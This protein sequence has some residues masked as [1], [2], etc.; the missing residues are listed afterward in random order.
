M[1]E[2]AFTGLLI[3]CTATLGG[4]ALYAAARLFKGS[5]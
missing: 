2:V 5:S 3:A 4:L 1:T